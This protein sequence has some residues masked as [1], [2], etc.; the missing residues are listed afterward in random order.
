MK[1]RSSARLFDVVASN[2]FVSLPETERGHRI[3]SGVNDQ[4]FRIAGSVPLG[5]TTG[6]DVAIAIM[7][8]FLYSCSAPAYVLTDIGRQFVYKFFGAVCTALGAK[9]YFTTAYCPQTNKRIE[10]LSKTFVQRLRHYV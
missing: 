4:L 7:D 3:V 5:T 2:L 9:N 1:L 10:R 6:S 8:D